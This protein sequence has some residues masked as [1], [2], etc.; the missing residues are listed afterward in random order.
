MKHLAILQE[1]KEVPTY[2]YHKRRRNQATDFGI[3]LKEKLLRSVHRYVCM[4]IREQ[5]NVGYKVTTLGRFIRHNSVTS[6]VFTVTGPR[7]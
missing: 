6:Y 2:R 7:I 1:F 3:T 5:W 4:Y